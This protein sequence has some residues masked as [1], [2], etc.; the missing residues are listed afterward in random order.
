MKRGAV[1]AAGRGD[2]T[3][4]GPPSR[5]KG[6]GAADFATMGLRGILQP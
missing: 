1:E 4:D 3:S 6:F 2:R 5:L